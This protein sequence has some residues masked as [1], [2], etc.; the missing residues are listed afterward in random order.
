MIHNLQAHFK[1][2]VILTNQNYN[3]LINGNQFQ[4][5]WDIVIANVPLHGGEADVS[6]PMKTIEDIK[7]QI[8]ATTA[9][10]A[11]DHRQSI[12]NQYFPPA[13]AWNWSGLFV[14]IELTQHLFSCFYLFGFIISLHNTHTTILLYLP[15]CHINHSRGWSLFPLHHCRIIY[16]QWNQE[17]K[18]DFPPPVTIRI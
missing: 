7:L 14:C 12:P 9:N 13:T 11:S 17:D 3:C 2:Y 4:I 1:C 6:G 5:C 16:S 18:N 8:N 15:D 10:Y